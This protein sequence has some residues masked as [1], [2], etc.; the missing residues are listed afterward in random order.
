MEVKNRICSDTTIAIISALFLEQLCMPSSRYVRRDSLQVVG[1]PHSCAY[2]FWITHT[3]YELCQKNWPQFFLIGHLCHKIW[4]SC[5]WSLNVWKIVCC[6]RL[7]ILNCFQVCYLFVSIIHFFAS[8]L[9]RTILHLLGNNLQKPTSLAHDEYNMNSKPTYNE[10]VE[11]TAY[12][13]GQL[14]AKESEIESM[15]ELLESMKEQ[16]DL[17]ISRLQSD[18]SAP[19]EKVESPSQRVENS[20]DESF[21]QAL[22]SFGRQNTEVRNSTQKHTN[23]EKEPFTYRLN[24]LSS[25]EIHDL[26]RAFFTAAENGQIDHVCELV[27]LKADVNSHDT[28]PYCSSTCHGGASKI[29]V[30]QFSIMTPKSA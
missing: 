10:L 24:G 16:K 19:S 18:L 30:E 6:S 13:L 27:R 2:K 11:K 4:N 21:S 26:Q 3:N 5:S 15:K 14:R 29:E 17:E 23:S 12:L 20:V 7:P 8:A 22:I 25:L 9:T 28:T 1:T